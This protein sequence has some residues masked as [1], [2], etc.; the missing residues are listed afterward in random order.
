MIIQM[1]TLQDV[2]R[3]SA[4]QLLSSRVAE[5][6]SSCMFLTAAS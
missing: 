4:E 5:E 6:S 2:S 3:P 1:L